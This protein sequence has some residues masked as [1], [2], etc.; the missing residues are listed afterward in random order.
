[1]SATR[2]KYFPV[3]GVG[4]GGVNFKV[5]FGKNSI[6]LKFDKWVCLELEAIVSHGN[7]HAVDNSVALFV[8][9]P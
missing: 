5:L 2:W 6:S 7:M 4:R 1:M 8:C 3:W 9:V